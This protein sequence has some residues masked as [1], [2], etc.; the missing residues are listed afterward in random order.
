MHYCF[1]TQVFTSES[2]VQK[3]TF[4]TPEYYDKLLSQ[5]TTTRFRKK[6]YTVRPE[7]VEGQHTRFDK[8][9]TNSGEF[10]ACVNICEIVYYKDYVYKGLKHPCVG[11]G[12]KSFVHEVLVVLPNENTTRHKIVCPKIGL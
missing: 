2:G 8:L 9:S 4:C 3:R 12:H 11:Q 6:V 10:K 5:S 7:L 1:G